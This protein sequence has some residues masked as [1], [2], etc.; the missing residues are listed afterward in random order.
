VAI[1]PHALA[2]FV[3]RNLRFASFLQRAHKGFSSMPRWRLEMQPCDATNC[4]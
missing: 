1:L 3:F 4:N 2:A